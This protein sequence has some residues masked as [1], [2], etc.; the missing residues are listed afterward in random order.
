MSRS[1]GQGEGTV[2][3]GR[4]RP[5]AAHM[6]RKGAGIASWKSA[7]GLGLILG[8]AFILFPATADAAPPSRMKLCGDE[9]T[10]A[11]NAGKVPAG[12]TWQ[13]F[14][15][16][17]SARLKASDT[18]GAERKGA[19]ER[20]PRNPEDAK[21]TRPQSAQDGAPH[22]NRDAAGSSGQ[23][24]DASRAR[25]KQCGEEWRKLKAAG[26]VP[27]D[28][29]WPQFWSACNARLKTSG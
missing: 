3:C 19:K 15:K 21:R 18:S 1:R 9:W 16:G 14:Y 5:G 24:R 6:G 12:Q 23:G 27:A 29:K 28:Q 13:D 26:Q 25:Q 11:K 4:N 8:A 20:P 10:A 17:C 2:S 7:F 22:R